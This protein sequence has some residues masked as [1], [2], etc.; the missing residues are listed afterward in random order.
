M[1]K[2]TTSRRLAMQALFQLDLGQKDIDIALESVF[3]NDSFIE[4]TQE[5]AINLA[6]DVLENKAKID[7]I[8]EERAIGWT[9]D[10]IS[11]VDR[12]ILRIAIYEVLFTDTPKSVVIN[13]AV[14]LAKKFGTDDSSK[15]INGILGKFVEEKS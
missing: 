15:F 4:E 12:N 13:E 9:L 3:T 14:N 8:I 10:R 1:G 6:K 5:F 11:H 2:R 7:K